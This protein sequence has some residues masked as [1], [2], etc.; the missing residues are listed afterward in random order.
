M[1][2]VTQ[3]QSEKNHGFPKNYGN[4]L[5]VKAK[6]LSMSGRLRYDTSHTFAKATHALVVVLPL[7][8]AAGATTAVAGTRADIGTSAV[9]AAVRKR[10]AGLCSRVSDAGTFFRNFETKIGRGRIHR[11]FWRHLQ[12]CKTKNK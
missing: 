2:E 1:L 9:L 4:A 12:K 5:F 11:L 6:R 10:W 3:T 7:L 8:V